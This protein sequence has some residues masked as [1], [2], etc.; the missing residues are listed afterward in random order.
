MQVSSLKKEKSINQL[1]LLVVQMRPGQWTKN[2]LVFAALVFSFK[3]ATIDM[4][5]K[6]VY[7]F[8]LFL[9]VSSCVYILNDFV[10]SEA[11]QQHPVKR[12]RPLA[13][14]MLNPQLTMVFGGTLLITCLGLSAL[15]SVPFSILLTLY[16]VVNV[17]YSTALKQVVILDVMIVAS[18]FVLRAI[19]GAVLINVKLTPWF[20]I[21]IMLLSL[22]LAISKRRYEFILSQENDTFPRKVLNFYNKELLDQ[23]N[24]IVTT[25]TLISYA[26]FTFTSGR[27]IYLMWTIPLVFYGVFRY[28][29]LI[30][31]E[32]K[33]G[34]PDKILFEDKHIL[35]TILLYAVSVILILGYFE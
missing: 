7:G 5:I 20:L 3:S 26:L 16:F 19:G 17:L 11:D 30:H 18:G 15:F 31:V 34:D 21:C 4:V 9:L 32:G 2:L 29:Y 33:G 35:C 8:I 1:Y 28:L 12:Y 24:T 10:D 22:F 27:T 14:G 25:A 6:S 23:L 13:S